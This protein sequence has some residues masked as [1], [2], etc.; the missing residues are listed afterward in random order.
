MGIPRFGEVLNRPLYP[1]HLIAVALLPTISAWHWI[2][3]LHV[4]LKLAGLVLLGVELGWPAWLVILS[5][6]GAMLTFGALSHFGDVIDLTAAAWLPLQLWLTVKVTRSPGWTRWDVLWIACAALR[7]LGS[8]PNRV[9]YYEILIVLVIATF[10]WR[11]LRPQIARIVVRYALTSLLIAPLLLPALMHF[12][13]SA[14]AHFLEFDDW[15]FRRAYNWR[16]YWLRLSDLTGTVLVP[17]GVW[18]ALGGVLA[19]TKGR[20]GPLSLAL[21]GYALF[22]SL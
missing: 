13:D 22:E 17:Y 19:L 16:N 20:T 8:N 9:L 12:A 5:S 4:L 10:G 2:N 1:V 14:R 11:A 3:V 7:L 6:S 18:A 21:A 15:H